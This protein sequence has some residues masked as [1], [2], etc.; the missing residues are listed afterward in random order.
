VASFGVLDAERAASREESKS[1]MKLYYHPI[2]TTSRPIMLFAAESK[3]PLTLQ[4]VACSPAS[5]S[6]RLTRR[7][8]EQAGAGAGGR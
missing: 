7:S 5:T 4:V 6:S 3:I 2:S 1:T 8:T